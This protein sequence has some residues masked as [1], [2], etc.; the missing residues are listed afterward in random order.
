MA[1]RWGV[2][3]SEAAV[4]RAEATVNQAQQREAEA[5]EQPRWHRH[6]Q[7]F[8]TP[9][10]A[11]AAL[12]TLARSWTY[13]QVDASSRIDHTRYAAQG[14]PTPTT[15]RKAIAWQIQA[16]VQPH[17]AQMGQRKPHQACW[18]VGTNM[19]ASPVSDAEGMRASKGQ[20]QAAGGLRFLTDPLCVVSSLFVN[21]PSRIQ[22]LMR[23]M[24]GAVLVSAVA[25]R[26]LR[27]QLVRHNETV[28]HHMPHPTPRPTLRWVLQLLE[29]MHRVRVMV[30]GHVHDLIEG[31]H[32][33]PIKILRLFGEGL[34]R[35]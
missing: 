17:D 16:Q 15:P 30:Q 21:R 24:T 22:G 2:V 14:R 7:R 28:P 29:G 11:T 5:I 9:E 8:E 26:R 12:D 33:V 20:A 10:A 19:D 23:V 3:S 27:Q 32:E 18:V 34:C 6:A 35:L 25:Q 13:P 4:Q 31:L 1:Q